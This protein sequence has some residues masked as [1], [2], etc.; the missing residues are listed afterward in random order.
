MHAISGLFI[1]LGV[2]TI[3]VSGLLYLASL[4]SLIS[5]GLLDGDWATVGKLFGISFLV[6]PVGGSACGIMARML[7][8]KEALD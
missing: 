1:L 4:I 5:D 8:G 3:P 6:W 7:G 2:L